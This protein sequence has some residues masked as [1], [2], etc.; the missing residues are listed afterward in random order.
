MPLLAKTAAAHPDYRIVVTGHSLGGAVATLAAAQLRSEGW[1]VSLYSYGAPRVGGRALSAFI[2]GQVGGNYRVTHRNDP[3]PKLPLLIMG[4]VH[5]SPEYYV[6]A[7]NGAEVGAGD[8]RV[9]GGAVSLEGNGRWLEID[10]EAH[11]WYFGRVYG[12]KDRVKRE[13]GGWEIVG[14]F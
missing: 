10:A 11:R 7:V 4:F 14:R 12:C 5:V 2:S 6:D 13:V 8:V 9:Y 1:V 3:V